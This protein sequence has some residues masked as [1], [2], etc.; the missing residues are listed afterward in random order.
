M[1]D[2]SLLKRVRATLAEAARRVDA[3]GT[4]HASRRLR[5]RT[6]RTETRQA[7]GVRAPADRRAAGHRRADR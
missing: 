3:S 2:E 6:A 7:H 5:S 1:I 4:L